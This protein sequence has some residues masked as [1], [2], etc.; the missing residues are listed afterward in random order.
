MKPSSKSLSPSS[1]TSTSTFA[2]S[3]TPEEMVEIRRKGVLIT[4]STA[5]PLLIML[6][7]VAYRWSRERMTTLDKATNFNPRVALSRVMWL[8][9]WVVSSR[10]G[11]R[12]IARI[13]YSNE[14]VKKGIRLP[15]GGLDAGWG[16]E[17]RQLS[18]QSL[19]EQCPVNHDWHRQWEWIAFEWG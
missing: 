11:V 16:E 7:M 3:I 4:Q 8:Y 13:C 1:M 17:G 2:K 10:V 18:F 14:S 5:I 12:I 9:T 6:P 19:W 15:R